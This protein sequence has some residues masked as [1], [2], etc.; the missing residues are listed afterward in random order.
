MS[1]IKKTLY[2]IND[3]LGTEE[4]IHELENIEQKIFK[5]KHRQ[6]KIH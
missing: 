5:V 6:K 1:D 2:G 4:K 3:R